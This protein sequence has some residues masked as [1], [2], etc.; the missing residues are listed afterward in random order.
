ML[1]EEG[2]E[3]MVT[4][5]SVRRVRS[6]RGALAGVDL[7]LLVVRG[8]LRTVAFAFLTPERRAATRA[9]FWRLTERLPARRFTI[10][11]ARLLS[12]FADRLGARLAIATSFPKP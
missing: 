12:A 9:F 7:G 5:S 11:F 2:G 1:S 6:S 3:G 8:A 10:R 4:S